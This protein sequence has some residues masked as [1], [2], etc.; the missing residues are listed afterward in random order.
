MHRRLCLGVLASLALPGVARA[1]AINNVP[2]DNGGGWMTFV[3]E[4]GRDDDMISAL[5]MG[6]TEGCFDT[7]QIPLV[8]GRLFHQRETESVVI[9]TESMARAPLFT[10]MTS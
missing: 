4:G 1:C 7:L 2:L 10:A 5:P 3:V 6:V 8:R 9:L